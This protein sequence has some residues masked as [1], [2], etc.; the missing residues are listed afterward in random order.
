MHR[1]GMSDDVSSADTNIIP[2]VR[3]RSGR[4][5]ESRRSPGDDRGK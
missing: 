5:M 1:G 3:M 4:P 2:Q